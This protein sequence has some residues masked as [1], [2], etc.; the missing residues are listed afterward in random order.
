MRSARD[1]LLIPVCVAIGACSTSVRF[2]PVGGPYSEQP[3][4]PVLV[5]TAKGIMGNNGTLSLELPD[6]IECNGEWSSAAGSGVSVASYGL[7]GKYGTV[8]GSGT[9]ISPGRGQ[10]PGS[11]ILMCGGGRRILVEFITGAGTANGFGFAEDSEGNVYRVL[12]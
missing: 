11:G 5:A 2:Y 3:N 12:F 4:P 9:S 1:F 8:Y 10:N 6:G 7:F